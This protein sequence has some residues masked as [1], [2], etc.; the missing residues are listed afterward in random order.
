MIS[1]RQ[2]DNAANVVK[3]RLQLDAAERAELDQAA[4][5][6]WARLPAD[7]QWLRDWEYV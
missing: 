5:R 6:M 7:Y 3:E 4:K 1:I 2:V